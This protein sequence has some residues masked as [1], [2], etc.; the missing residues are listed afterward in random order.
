MPL[1]GG[2][3]RFLVEAGVRLGR[4][5]KAKMEFKNQV[6]AAIRSGEAD[7]CLLALI[8]SPGS[9]SRTPQDAYDVLQEIWLEF[10]FDGRS[11][12]GKIQDTL[13]FLMEKTWQECPL[14][15]SLRR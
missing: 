9:G 10:G 3:C 2:V 7:D 11:H 14:A 15:E 5:Q 13:E 6:V 4:S 8:H 12:G 1:F